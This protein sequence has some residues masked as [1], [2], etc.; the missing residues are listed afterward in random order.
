MLSK[1]SAFMKINMLDLTKGLIT[2]IFG[3]IGGFILPILQSGS[4]DF[5]WTTILKAAVAAAFGYLSKQLFTNSDGQF[6]KKET[7]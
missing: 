7:A 3:A 1:V 4:F 2:A 6:M 5:N